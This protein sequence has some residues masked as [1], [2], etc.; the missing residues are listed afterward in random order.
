MSEFPKYQYS[1]P[2]SN[3][4]M[5]VVRTDDVAEFQ[6]LVTKVKNA[7][8]GGERPISDKPKTKVPYMWEGD[9]CPV[10]NAGTLVKTTKVSKQGEKY[11]ALICSQNSC[12]GYA[13]LSKYPKQG[14]ETNDQYEETMNTEDIPF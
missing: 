14:E 6:I 11:T 12:K 4:G 3:G 5:Y 13:Y 8:G 10:C 7:A 9:T 1:Q 2:V